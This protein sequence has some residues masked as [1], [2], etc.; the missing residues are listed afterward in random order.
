M[1]LF[2]DILNPEKF[3]LYFGSGPKKPAPAAPPVTE[4]TVEVVEQGR[5]MRKDMQ[6]LQG[7][8][9]TI[10]AGGTDGGKSLL[11]GGQ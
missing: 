11:G 1:K 3:F 8:K 4:R 6:K 10:F 9:S 2:N 5:K 7:F